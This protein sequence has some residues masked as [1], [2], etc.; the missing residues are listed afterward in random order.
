VNNSNNVLTFSGIIFGPMIP[1]NCFLFGSWIYL[2][3]MGEPGVNSFF[4]N[5]GV[6]KKGDAKV[7]ENTAIKN[8][9]PMI[10][11]FKYILFR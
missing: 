8:K 1:K 10:Y 3:I 11:V 2:G 5:Q 9:K 6:K 4:R 7:F